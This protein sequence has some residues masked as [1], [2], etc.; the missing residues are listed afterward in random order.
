MSPHL[1]CTVPYEALDAFFVVP[2]A[3]QHPR[4]NSIARVCDLPAWLLLIIVMIVA[5]VIMLCLANYS[6]KYNKEQQDYRSMSG[7]LSIAWT[8]MLGV[9]VPRQARSA[10]I[11]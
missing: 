7:C 8:A 5:A 4:W 10:P 6:T 11:M 1:D 9:S 3:K 2:R